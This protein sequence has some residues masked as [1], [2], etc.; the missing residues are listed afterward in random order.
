MK[1]YSFLGLALVGAAGVTA[2]F[3]PAKKADA[4]NGKIAAG[5]YQLTTASTPNP[6]DV[7]DANLYTCT[8]TPDGSSLGSCSYT[9]TGFNAGQS[10]TSIAGNTHSDTIDGNVTGSATTADYI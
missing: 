10:A 3:I 2:A 6:G 4:G 1:N 7:T 9:Q 8:Q 5:F